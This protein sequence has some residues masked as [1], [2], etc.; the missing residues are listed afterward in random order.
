MKTELEKQFEKNKKVWDAWMRASVT[1][2]TVL[3]VDFKF[4]AAKK[5]SADALSKILNEHGYIFKVVPTRTFLFFKGFE[6]V[7]SIPNFDLSLENIN[8]ASSMF[9][10]AAFKSHSLFEGIGALIPIIKK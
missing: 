5:E 1:K 6:I 8:D 2:D 9:M 3:T 4:Y 7:V 10:G